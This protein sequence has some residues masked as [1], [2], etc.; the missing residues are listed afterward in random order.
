[1]IQQVFNTQCKEDCEKNRQ[2]LMHL[3]ISILIQVRMWT[4]LN[5]PLAFN[6]SHTT[7]SFAG[8][9]CSEF[10]Q[11]SEISTAISGI[12]GPI[13]GM[14]V[15]IWLHSSRWFQI[16][17]W[18]SKIL[19]NLWTFCEHFVQILYLSSAQVCRT[20]SV[21]KIIR[22]YLVILPYMGNPQFPYWG[23]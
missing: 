6:T 7:I 10:L 3:N 18:N 14:F 17:S 9:N 22:T 20:I 4:Q 11:N 2:F 21:K 8:K 19:T 13:L 5:R 23:R 12:T 15:L 16:W 1:M